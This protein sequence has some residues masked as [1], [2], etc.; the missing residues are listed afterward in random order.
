MHTYTTETK[1]NL[2][3]QKR[4]MSTMRDKMTI[5]IYMYIYMRVCVEQKQNLT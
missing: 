1:S 5:Y 2:T 4:T 3:D